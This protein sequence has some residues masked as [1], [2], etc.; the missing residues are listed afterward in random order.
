[1]RN[2]IFLLLLFGCAGSRDVAPGAGPVGESEYLYLWAASTDSTEPDFLAVLDVRPDTGRYGALVATVP[3][4]SGQNGPHHTEHQL[5]D[6]G[7]LFANGF[8]SGRSFIFDVR[9]GARPRLVGQ[10]GEQAGF[11]HPH[12]FLRMPSGNV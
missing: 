5:A 7:Q 8:G 9:N 2:P 3:V 6:D 11:G 12:S 10:F 4:G 1:M